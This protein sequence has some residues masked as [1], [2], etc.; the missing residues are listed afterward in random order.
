LKIQTHCL[1]C[2]KNNQFKGNLEW[3]VLQINDESVYLR[4][5]KNGHDNL[6][7]NSNEKYELLFESACQA[8]IDGYYKEAASSIASSLERL[9][10]Y[11][12]K[13]ISFKNK[14]ESDDINLS[15]NEMKKQS[16]RQLGAYI[17]M[18]LQTFKKKAPLLPNKQIEFRNDI[19][20]KGYFP[21]YEEV[22]DFGEAVLK[23]IYNVLTTLKQ[24]CKDGISKYE[25]FK[26]ADLLRKTE[27]LKNPINLTTQSLLRNATLD[28]EFSNGMTLTTYLGSFKRQNYS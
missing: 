20:H 2:D 28:N 15:W 23:I 19:I 11:S 3:I 1:Q 6:F 18:Y 26:S 22:V 27:G 24:N 12:I 4:K 13:V 9:Y 14:V 25:A 8:I 10:E 5:C 7:I 16:E 17:F 21:T